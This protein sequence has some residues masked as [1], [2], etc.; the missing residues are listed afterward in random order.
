MSQ[1]IT[2]AEFAPF[3][4][5]AVGKKSQGLREYFLR[6]WERGLGG[7]NANTAKKLSIA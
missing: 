1:E 7:R 3:L 4:L 5:R 6:G 2:G